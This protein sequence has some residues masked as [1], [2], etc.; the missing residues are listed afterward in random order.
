MKRIVFLT[1]TRADF[2]KLK[3]LMSISQNSKNFDVH[4]FVTGMHMN[5]VYGST[6]DEVIKAGF[7]NIYKYINHNSGETMDKTL[8]K[9]IE[10]FSQYIS[11]INPDL[12]VV[13]GDRLEALAGAMVGSLNNILVSHIE[14]G[15]VSGTID[16]VYRHC[17]TK[18]CTVHFVSSKSAKNRVTKLG[19][20]PD[21]VFVLG[22]PELDA[23]KKRDTIPL[24]EVLSYYDIQWDKYGIFIFHSVTS[25]LES[26]KK[27]IQIC[28]DSLKELKKNFVVIAPNNDPGCEIIFK[29]IGK[30]PASRFKQIPSMRCAYF[31]TLLKNSQIIVGNSSVGVREAP[32][33]GVPSINIGSRQFR[34]AEAKSIKNV[35]VFKNKNF[36]KLVESLWGRRFPTDNSFGTGQSAKKFTKIL[37]DKKIW[38][39]NLQ[40]AFFETSTK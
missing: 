25:E 32:F 29:A 17:N 8:A 14:G 38:K 27:E 37:K 6:V 9:T 34:R 24:H 3:S 12:I 36:D 19:E 31:S 35:D 21:R 30:L 33:L 28:C 15:E 40:K 23:H 10:G 4:L 5:S 20:H 26:L 11:Q 13:H 39:L 18:L 7:K 22:S 2:G 1:G 16:E